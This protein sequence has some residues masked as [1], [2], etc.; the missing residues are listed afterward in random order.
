M[1]EEEA[2]TKWCPMARYLAIFRNGS[3]SIDSIAA[4]NRGLDDS[5]LNKSQCIASDCMMWRLRRFRED[6]ADGYC[7]L[8][9]NP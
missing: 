5:G 7:G 6:D 9:G 3:G 8:A 2:K 1:T 4:Y